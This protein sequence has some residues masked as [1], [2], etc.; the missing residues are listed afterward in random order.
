MAAGFDPEPAAVLAQGAGSAG[1]AESRQRGAEWRGR[2]S[3]QSHGAPHKARDQ[4]GAETC[5]EVRL[6]S[7]AVG[8][9]SAGNML[10]VHASRLV[11]VSE[12]NNICTPTTICALFL[13]NKFH[14]FSL[15][16]SISKFC[17]F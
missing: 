10:Q 17:K 16:I 13:N 11:F 3:R 7:G 8:Q 5:P 4:V 6:L 12:Y 1:T 14:E 9:V 2:N 15:V